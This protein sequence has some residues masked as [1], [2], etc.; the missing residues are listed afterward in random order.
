MDETPSAE[1]I[2]STSTVIEAPRKLTKAEKKALYKPSYAEPHDTRRRVLKDVYMNEKDDNLKYEL[3]TSILYAVYESDENPYLA[4]LELH[5]ICPD[6][7]TNK[8]KSLAGLTANSL[9]SW[10]LKQENPTEIFEQ[11]VTKELQMEAFRV[12]TAKHTGYL[13]LFKELFCLD[14]RELLPLLKEE[15]NVW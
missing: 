1:N 12:A 3:L 13:K 4:M 10:L 7:S 2:S 6:Y 9:R 8:P 14:K 5:K 15:I 11:C